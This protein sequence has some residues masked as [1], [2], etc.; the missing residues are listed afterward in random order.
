LKTVV[1]KHSSKPTDLVIGISVGSEDLYRLSESG[2]ENKAGIGA[3]PTV[4]LNFIEKV[5]EVIAGT[6]LSS[7]PVGHVNS[8]SAWS[9]E[10]NSAVINAFDFLGM[11]LYL[12]M[13]RI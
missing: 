12:T 8:W 11:D 4:I 5:R 10:S 7:I 3:G 9:N 13:R 1:D 6:V 2:I